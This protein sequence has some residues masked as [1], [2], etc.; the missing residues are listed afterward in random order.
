MK[1]IH[2]PNEKLIEIA[3]INS[4]KKY[5]SVT[6]LTGKLSEDAINQWKAKVG[7][8]VAEKVMKESSER[9]TC[10]HKFCED[11]QPIG[12]VH[13]GK[14]LLAGC[15]KKRLHICNPIE[16]TSQLIEQNNIKDVL[17]E[18]EYEFQRVKYSIVYGWI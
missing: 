18:E 1:F 13:E 15:N 9:G 11:T 4:E 10:I 17:Y 8:E 3:K 2:Q 12:R 6:K 5:L 7:I 14:F 16:S